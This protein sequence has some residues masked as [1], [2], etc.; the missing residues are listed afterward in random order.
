[1]TARQ[2]VLALVL[3][4]LAW[5]SVEAQNGSVRRKKRPQVR[6][7]APAAYETPPASEVPY[8][9][10][11]FVDKLDGPAGGCDDCGSCDS[12]GPCTGSWLLGGPASC[13]GAGGCGPWNAGIEL[14]FL[15]PYFESNPVASVLTSDGD[16]LETFNIVEFDYQTELAPRVWL[17]YSANC[18]MGFRVIW[19]QFDHGA[20]PEALSPDANGFGRITP[21]DFGDIDLSTT[22]PGSTY[23]AATNLEAWT[24]DI[25]ATRAFTGGC[26]TW[27]GA[28]GVRYAEIDQTYVSNLQSAEGNLQGTIDYAHGAEVFG[29]TVY[30]RAQRPVWPGVSLFGSVRGS[31]LFGDSFSELVAGEDLDLDDQLRTERFTNRDDLLPIGEVQVGLQVLTPCIGIH[32]PYLHV[33][34]EGQHWN[35]A[36]NASSEDGSLGFFGFNVA[37]G[38][39]W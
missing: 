3:I 9:E 14:T 1:M 28:A 15:Q 13:T 23:S 22:V 2:T 34:L 17:E 20:E 24:L 30:M 36:G 25:E 32:Q 7:V 12:C 31:L 33:A 16:T 11:A 38:L 37:L 26:W 29:P 4:A 35:G 10:P 21:P 39:S 8:D 27:L 6:R 19:W 5:G 18:N